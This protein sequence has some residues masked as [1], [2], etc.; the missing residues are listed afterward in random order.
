MFGIHHIRK[1]TEYKAIRCHTARGIISV[2]RGWRLLVG[3]REGI[4]DGKG[5]E[6]GEGR[7]ARGEVWYPPHQERLRVEDQALPFHARHHLC[8]TEVGV[9]G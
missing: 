5:K 1:D 8:K 9:C 7:G 6:N 2:E 4:G 3:K